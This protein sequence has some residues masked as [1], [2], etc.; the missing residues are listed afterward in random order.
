[1]PGAS[2][3]SRSANKG[4]KP[5]HQPADAFDHGLLLQRAERDAEIT[6]VHRTEGLTWNDCHSVLTNQA[7]GKR[8]RIDF[9]VHPD[10]T[11]ER[12]VDRRYGTQRLERPQ[13]RGD[14]IAHLE[15]RLQVM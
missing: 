11:V 2:H 12:T 5:V 15:E 3:R 10:E 14:Q 6:A 1:M 8:H 4:A 13:L 9:R 7:L